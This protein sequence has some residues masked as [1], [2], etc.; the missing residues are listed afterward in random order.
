M[1]ELID[2]IGTHHVPVAKLNDGTL[3]CRIVSLVP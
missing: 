1:S 3:D 2:A